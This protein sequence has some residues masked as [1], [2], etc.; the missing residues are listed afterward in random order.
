MISDYAK[1]YMEGCRKSAAREREERLLL[2]VRPRPRWM[3]VRIYR[4]LLSKLLWLE[5]HR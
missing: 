4:W 3:P 1:G 2:V 5:E